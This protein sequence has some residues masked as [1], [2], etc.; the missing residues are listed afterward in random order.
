MNLEARWGPAVLSE[1]LGLRHLFVMKSTRSLRA[2]HVGRAFLQ[3]ALRGVS[4][5]NYLSDIKLSAG[6]CG[7][8]E[9]RCLSLIVC[10]A[11]PRPKVKRMGIFP[12]SPWLVVKPIITS[13]KHTQIPSGKQL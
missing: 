1:G 13:P 11:S 5:L 6:I 2:T 3:M 7:Q 9:L 10:L 4:G 12:S 8:G